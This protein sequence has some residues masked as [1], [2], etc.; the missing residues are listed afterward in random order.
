LTFGHNR[1]EEDT[2]LHHGALPKLSFPK[3]SGDN[4]KIWIDKCGDY[5][6]IFNVPKCMWTTTASL[7]MEENA[8]RW[9]QVYKMKKGLGD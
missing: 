1:Q 9:L 3:F 8:A 2:L 4:P 7:H 6:H 5:F